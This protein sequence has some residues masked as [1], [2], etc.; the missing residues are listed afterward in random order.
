MRSRWATLKLKLRM[1]L[2]TLFFSLITL[3]SFGQDLA[4]NIQI[5]AD[6]DTAFWANY[7]SPIIEKLK[8]I[9][10]SLD[11]DFFRISSS[12]YFLELS[13]KSNRI[14]FYVHE[15]WES[16]QT[17]ETYIKSFDIDSEQ[18]KKIKLLID[19]LEINKIPSGKYIS[20]W[21]HGL[22]GITYVFENKN[23]NNYSFKNYWTPSSQETLKEA[24]N[25]LTFTNQ[26]D[27]IIEYSPK[28]KLFESEIPFYGWTYNGSSMAAIRV[29]SNTKEYRRYKR[30]KKRQSRNQE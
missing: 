23:G 28:R 29:I 27:T 8:L 1:R 19:T 6:S 25:I 30:M 21:A 5:T 15:I 24:Q 17:G 16:N 26:L 12:K 22:D 7:Y 4:K 18:V 10:P 2:L 9:N 14:L 13:Q 3:N 20:G 11:T